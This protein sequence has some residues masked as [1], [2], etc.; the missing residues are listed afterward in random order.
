MGEGYKRSQHQSGVAAATPRQ[1][2]KF[3]IRNSKQIQMFKKTENSKQIQNGFSVLDFP[4]LG[5]I[6]L[7]F[8]SDFVLRISDLLS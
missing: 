2:Q 7:R 6:W 3:E 5:F 4:S 8:V 1:D